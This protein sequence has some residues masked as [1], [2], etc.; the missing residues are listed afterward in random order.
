M[1]QLKITSALLLVK[2]GCYAKYFL[3]R[4]IGTLLHTYTYI[5]S[6]GSTEPFTNVFILLVFFIV[7]TAAS[8]LVLLVFFVVCVAIFI[9]RAR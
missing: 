5:Y 1:L 8:V 2:V 7:C 6:H 4:K 3:R 9:P